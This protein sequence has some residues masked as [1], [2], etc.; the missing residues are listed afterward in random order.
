MRGRVEAKDS[1]QSPQEKG[2]VKKV[3][4]TTKSESS[5]ASKT[6]SEDTLLTQQESLTTQAR[7]APRS[8]LLRQ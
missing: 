7:E 4:N 8:E 5:E 3:E 2:K 6:P 1:L